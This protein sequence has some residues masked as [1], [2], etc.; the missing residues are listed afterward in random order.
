MCSA[1][2]ESSYTRIIAWHLVGGRILAET[3]PL[4]RFGS[5]ADASDLQEE[6]PPQ[7]GTAAENSRGR[8]YSPERL[9][10]KTRCARVP[11]EKPAAPVRRGTRDGMR[12][13]AT[14]TGDPTY[15]SDDRQ[16]A[17]SQTQRRYCWVRIAGRGRAVRRGGIAL[18]SAQQPG[19]ATNRSASG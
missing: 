17:I 19:G 7:L 2:R 8:T 9:R 18:C 12:T 14:P 15:A 11:S 3:L 6:D 10:P 13:C 4:C 5:R 1:R 16:S